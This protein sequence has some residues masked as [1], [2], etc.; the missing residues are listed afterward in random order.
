RKPKNSRVGPI[1]QE[2]MQNMLE[3]DIGGVTIFGAT[4]RSAATDDYNLPSVY[5][6]NEFVNDFGGLITL[7]TQPPNLVI[8]SA[9]QLDISLV[10]KY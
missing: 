4:R 5:D 2:I 10:E 1:L 9:L 3:A 7:T 6:H 8:P